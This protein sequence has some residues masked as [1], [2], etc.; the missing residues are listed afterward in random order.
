MSSLSARG[1]YIGIPD[2][3]LDRPWEACATMNDAWG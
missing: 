3:P 1:G 2:A